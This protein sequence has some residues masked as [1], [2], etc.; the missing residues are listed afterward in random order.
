ME[1]RLDNSKPPIDWG[2]IGVLGLCVEFWVILVTAVAY[3]L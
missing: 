2:L 3:L 1:L